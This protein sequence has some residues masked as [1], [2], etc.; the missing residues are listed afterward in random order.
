MYIRVNAWMNFSN[1]SICS[2]VVIFTYMRCPQCACAR[3]IYVTDDTGT[4]HSQKNIVRVRGQVK[5]VVFHST[6]IE[7]EYLLG[8]PL[9]NYIISVHTLGLKFHSNIYGT[10]LWSRE[11]YK[12]HCLLVYTNYASF[13]CM[14][15]V[16]AIF[17]K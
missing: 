1:P 15:K 11:V 9:L 12:Q 3:V 7:S 4:P 5:A 10:F 6:N 14:E 2:D 8:F 17:H 13:G 16:V